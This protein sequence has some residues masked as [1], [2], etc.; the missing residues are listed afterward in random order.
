MAALLVSTCCWQPLGLNIGSCQITVAAP[1][2]MAKNAPGMLRVATKYP[3]LAARHFGARGQ[4]VE[5]IELSGSVELAPVLGLADCIIDVVET[6][7]T[8]RENGLSVVEVIANSNAQ[9]VVNRASYQLKA[10]AIGNLIYALKRAVI[11]V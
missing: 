6:G 2:G 11:E 4:P 1:D 8:L 3:R 7:K 10:K 5:I 9:L